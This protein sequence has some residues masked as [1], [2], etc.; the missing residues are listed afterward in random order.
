MLLA[1][2][3]YKIGGAEL[4]QCHDENASSVQRTTFGK[5]VLWLSKIMKTQPLAEAKKI[6]L[7]LLAELIALCYKLLKEVFA[8]V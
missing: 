7:N 2:K 6:L 4:Q 1:D 3:C 8:V 5:E